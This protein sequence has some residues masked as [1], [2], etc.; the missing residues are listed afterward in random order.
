MQQGEKAKKPP[1]KQPKANHTGN[2][3]CVDA[4][5]PHAKPRSDTTA[6]SPKR[7]VT[8]MDKD[9]G[10]AGPS[11][12]LSKPAP[13]KKS[14]TPSKP[15]LMPTPTKA[16]VAAAAHPPPTSAHE[17]AALCTLPVTLH[18]LE[19]DSL[20]VWPQPSGSCHSQHLN[21]VAKCNIQKGVLDTVRDKTQHG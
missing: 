12:Q 18:R 11:S 3:S 9:M 2:T 7:Q 16:L 14:S 20:F 5:L 1:K 21:T 15:P 13:S 4:S 6:L 10:N 17:A 8:G 19:E